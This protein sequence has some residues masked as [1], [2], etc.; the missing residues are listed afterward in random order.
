MTFFTARKVSNC[1]IDA[2]KYRF[3]YR[4]TLQVLSRHEAHIL[5]CGGLTQSL[6][7]AIEGKDHIVI[8]SRIFLLRPFALQ[9]SEYIKIGGRMA[10]F[11][12]R[13]QKVPRRAI[14]GNNVDLLRHGAPF[15][16]G[17]MRD[18]LPPAANLNK[19]KRQVIC[20]IVAAQIL[21]ADLFV[22]ARGEFVQLG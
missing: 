22:G 4:I 6:G 18:L 13:E 2:L 1:G 14:C 20:T 12:F 21:D 3:M 16:L 15:P 7:E 19:V 5:L 10:K 11:T 8:V 9:L 17:G